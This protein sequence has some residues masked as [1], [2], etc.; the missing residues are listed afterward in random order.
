M[1]LRLHQWRSVDLDD[2]IRELCW[3]AA[4]AADDAEIMSILKELRAELAEH[5]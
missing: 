4:A 3:K 5:N 1:L 2:R